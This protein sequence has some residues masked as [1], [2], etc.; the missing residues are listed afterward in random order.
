M[1]ENVSQLTAND[2]MSDSFVRVDAKDS[3]SKLLSALKKA[4][5]SNALVFDGKTFVGLASDSALLRNV[6]L[7]T[8][9]VSSVMRMPPSVSPSTAFEKVARLLRDGDVRLI[10]VLEKGKVIGVIHARALLERLP[11]DPSFESVRAADF[12]TTNPL[13]L[14]PDDSLDH[15]IRLMKDSNVRNLPVLDKQRKP[16]GVIHLESLALNVLLPLDRPGKNS[17]K[18]G[19]SSQSI[20]KG[21]GLAIKVKA[22]MDENVPVISSA[23][24]GKS[25][26]KMLA[27]QPNP[28]LLVANNG[29]T[30]LISV[31]SVLDVFLNAMNESV[32]SPIAMTRL[33]DIDEVDRA[34]VEQMLQRTYDKIARILKAEDNMHVVF[35]QTKKSQLRARTEVHITLSGT[36]RTFHAEAADWKVLLAAR[37]ACRA[38]EAEVVKRY[39]RGPNHP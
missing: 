28:V 19:R 1:P 39:K 6:D 22:L 25:I 8:A 5:E 32:K 13:V 2:L 27:A 31:Q 23:E 14:S 34:N 36:G 9:K 20:S 30:G 3:V 37:E 24:K 10:P 15:A 16:V 18:L 21:P 7:T 4:G 26:V 38:L 33:P 17:F 35:K 29:M 12:M 11:S